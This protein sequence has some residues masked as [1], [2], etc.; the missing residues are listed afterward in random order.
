MTGVTFGYD[1]EIDL[2]KEFSKLNTVDPQK[3]ICT[4]DV[5]I[6]F[7]GATQCIEGSAIISHLGSTVYVTSPDGQVRV[8]GWGPAIGDEGSGYAIGKSALSLITREHDRGEPPSGLWEC[9]DQWLSS[10]TT[11][12][13][14]WL[15]ASLMWREIRDTVSGISTGADSRPALFALLHRLR[16][17]DRSFRYWHYISSFTEPL[18]RFIDD[19]VKDLTQTAKYNECI[20]AI[21]AQLSSLLAQYSLALSR[22]AEAYNRPLSAS[23]LIL[24]GGVIDH[25]PI[26]RDMLVARLVAD[27]GI[28]RE[29]IITAERNDFL[30]P[31][32]GALLFALG[33]SQTTQL[34]L[35]D[36]KVIEAVRSAALSK[37]EMRYA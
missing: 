11:P 25:Q 24:A 10:P 1:R 22:H 4:G 7:S 29:M 26:F 35:P 9:M 34:K 21:E 36:K 30:R 8:G 3:L 28:S 23:P 37:Q 14:D 18:F 31:A 2:P 12:V 17:N 5:E 13:N 33:N 6:L 15:D 20:Q 16:R 19:N 32:V 27:Y